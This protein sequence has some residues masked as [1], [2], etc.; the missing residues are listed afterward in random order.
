MVAEADGVIVAFPNH[1]DLVSAAFKNAYDWISINDGSCPVKEKPFAMM[2]SSQYGSTKAL[3]HF[4]RVGGYCKI[5][6]CEKYVNLMGEKEDNV[7]HNGNIV[8]EEVMAEV[9][10]LLESFYQMILANKK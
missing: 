6:V 5:K 9:G 10:Q 1:N 2:S 4:K 3:D 7:D 8:N